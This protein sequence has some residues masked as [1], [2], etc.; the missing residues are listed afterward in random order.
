VLGLVRGFFRDAQVSGANGGLLNGLMCVNCDS[1]LVLRVVVAPLGDAAGSAYGCE[2]ALSGLRAICP[3]V[4]LE[5]GT[6]R[7]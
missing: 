5:R 2:V 7:P 4:D 3:T 6:R 1:G